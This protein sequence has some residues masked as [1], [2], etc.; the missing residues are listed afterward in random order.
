[1]LECIEANVIDSCIEVIIGL[2]DIRKQRLIHRIPSYFDAPELA[3]LEPTYIP[4]INTQSTPENLAYGALSAASVSHF[5]CTPNYEHLLCEGQ[6]LAI[7][8]HHLSAWDM[9]TLYAQQMRRAPQEIRRMPHPSI[10]EIDLIR[11]GSVLD[12]IEDDDDIEWP[13]NPYEVNA[14]DESSESPVELLALITI[15][16]TCN[17][18]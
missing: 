7:P 9:I 10:T 2:P 18:D 13:D 3:F 14:L 17:G 16:R 5:H 4:E 8:V 15:K 1:V 11:K 6:G 12:P